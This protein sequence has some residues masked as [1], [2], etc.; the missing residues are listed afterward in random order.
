MGK[1]AQQ[2]RPKDVA[3]HGLTFNAVDVETAN[4][5]NSTICQIGI[6]H[7]V[8]GEVDDTWGTLVDPEVQFSRGHIKIHGITSDKVKGA[9]TLPEIREVLRDRLH[10]KI[11]ISHMPF[12]RNAFGSAL[13]KYKLEQLSVYWMDSARITRRAWPRFRKKGYGLKNVADYIGIKF[14]HHD[15]TQDAVAAAK[16]TLA[17]CSKHKVDM[18]H[19]IK[20]LG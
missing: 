14:K 16:I 8:D 4:N 17:A 5:D 10:G 6:A 13:D 9:P 20:I 12:D 18:D 1:Y 3:G 19:W 7:V 2:L 11:L 15:A